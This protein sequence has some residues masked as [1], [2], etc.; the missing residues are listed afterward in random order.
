ML[1]V[2]IIIAHA[3]AMQQQAHLRRGTLLSGAAAADGQALLDSFD[4]HMDRALRLDVRAK[5]DYCGNHQNL[6]D[7]CDGCGANLRR[8]R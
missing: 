6:G 5:C 8:T 7:R 1:D 4:A 3:V 2:P